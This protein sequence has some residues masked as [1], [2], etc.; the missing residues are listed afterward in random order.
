MNI[1]HLLLALTGVGAICSL[2]SI[3]A[4]AWEAS[5]P[6]NVVTDG[7]MQWIYTDSSKTQIQSYKFIGGTELKVDPSNPNDKSTYDLIS[8]FNAPSS[9]IEFKKYLLTDPF[10]S[11]FRYISYVPVNYSFAD[12]KEHSVYQGNDGKSVNAYTTNNG[13]F[14]EGSAVVNDIRESTT[15]AHVG[16]QSNGASKGNWRYMGFNGNGT[17]AVT[18]PNFPA[19]WFGTSTLNTYNFANYRDLGVSSSKYDSFSHLKNLAI[20]L[21]R[22]AYPELDNSDWS[23]K[24]KLLTN[25]ETDT[26]ILEGWKVGGNYYRSATGIAS[27]D[28]TRDIQIEFL[29]IY[30]SRGKLVGVF[31]RDIYTGTWTERIDSNLTKDNTYTCKVRV[32]NVSGS[33]MKSNTISVD[34]GTYS[35]D[36]AQ[37]LNDYRS[38]Y[39]SSSNKSTIKSNTKLNNNQCYDLTGSFVISGNIEHNQY[40]RLNAMISN[41]NWASKDTTILDNDWAKLSLKVDNGNVKPTKIELVDPNTNQVVSETAPIPGKSYKIKYTYAYEGP[42]KDKDKVYKLQVNNTVT[43]TLNDGSTNTYSEE[44]VVVFKDVVN[45]REASVVTD[46]VFTFQTAKVTASTV[47]TQNKNIDS[48][49]SDNQKEEEFN[50]Y[51]NFTVS[52]VRIIPS[53]ERPTSYPATITATIK[54]DINVDVPSYNK[55][56]ETDIK[57]SINSN[58]SFTDHIHAGLNKDITHQ[59]S[60]T[61]NGTGS[62]PATVVINKPSNPSERIWESNYNDNTGKTNS[63]TDLDI[64]APENPYNGGCTLNSSNSYSSSTKHILNNFSGNYVNTPLYNTNGDK[65]GTN[66][67]FNYT[68]GSSSER[69]T[70]YTES[71]KIE[72]VL[73]KS[74]LTTDLKLGD[75]GWVDLKTTKGK[76]KAGYGYDLKIVVAYKTNAITSQP[77][78]I[79]NPTNPLSYHGTNKSYNG[80]STGTTVS[81]QMYMPNVYKDIYV[82]LSNGNILS[83]SG[84][85]G[86]TKAFVAKTVDSNNKEIRVEYTLATNTNGVQTGGKIYTDETA[87]D[88]NYSITVFTPN[89][90][91]ISNKNLCDKTTVS[92]SITGSMLDDNNDHIVQ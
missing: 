6:S 51:Y 62:I 78:A 14:K 43:Q 17:L 26:P 29:D 11:E 27:P 76:I 39:S 68:R 66:G 50:G 88:G 19:D 4:H 70:N 65:I 71:Y 31:K 58:T 60:I 63:N 21:L 12:F 82:K 86:T 69:T 73:F 91:G 87:T 30:D 33:E 16:N 64:V 83:A 92:Y 79:S 42:D 44:N 34:L 52:N 37:T 89:I 90:T 81:N 7:N 38:Y 25:P 3:S 23:S 72:K 22:K 48:N 84:I 35:G 45:G 56:F 61:V 28:L 24:L 59:V 54:Y 13:N 49:A 18:N 74:K 75:N 8:H 1:K 77:N 2:G 36:D 40:Y 5:T 85:Y 32:T 10:N 55:D 46:K 20:D 57:T 41:S 80:K 53:T 9:G 15:V 67:F 47:L